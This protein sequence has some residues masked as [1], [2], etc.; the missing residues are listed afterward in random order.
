MELGNEGLAEQDILNRISNILPEDGYNIGQ[1]KEPEVNDEPKPQTEVKAEKPAEVKPAEPEEVKNSAE[2]YEEIEIKGEKYSVPK[3]IKESI[4]LQADYTRKTMELAEQRK[5]LEKA[6]PKVVEEFKQKLTHYETLLGQSVANDQKIDWVKL[7]EQDPIEYLKQKELS[8]SRAKE[9][10]QIS[11]QRAQ[12]QAE[13]TRQTLSKEW[14]QLIAKRP[15]WKD[16]SVL[17]ADREKIVKS[18]A[19]VGYT[20][21]EINSISDHR[22]LLVADKARRYD[23]LMAA[24]TEVVKKI[25]KLPPKIERPGVSPSEGQANQAAMQRLR[26]TGSLDDATAALRSLMG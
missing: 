14:E 1:S 26:K 6:D 2:P 24:K 20:E 9:W 4:M 17:K 7:L 13:R 22:A 5:A 3:A 18:L 23:E 16:E 25:E 8:E 12:E 19:E 10:Q 15:E 21:E 11:T